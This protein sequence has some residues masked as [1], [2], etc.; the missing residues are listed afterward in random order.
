M[1]WTYYLIAVPAGLLYLGLLVF[2]LRSWALHPGTRRMNRWLWLVV[3]VIFSIVGPV[4][5]LVLGRKKAPR[6]RS[7]SCGV[8]PT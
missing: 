1:N 5:Y 2:A 4:A 3:I 6:D 8:G 7:V